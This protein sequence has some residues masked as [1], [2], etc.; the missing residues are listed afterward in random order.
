MDT[1]LGRKPPWDKLGAS[2]KAILKEVRACAF[3]AHLSLLYSYIAWIHGDQPY[4]AC[5][6]S[7][8]CFHMLI[9]LCILKPVSIW[10]SQIFFL[11]T[12]FSLPSLRIFKFSKFSLYCSSFLEILSQRMLMDLKVL[13]KVE[14]WHSFP[15]KAK[16]TDLYVPKSSQV[17]R[18]GEGKYSRLASAGCNLFSPLHFI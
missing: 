18:D 14:T 3:W 8:I 15:E 1:L 4:V 16:L 10:S 6:I 5:H 11:S 2:I 12:L 7:I 17:G 13:I 9:I